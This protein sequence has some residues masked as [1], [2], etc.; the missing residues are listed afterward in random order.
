MRHKKPAGEALQLGHPYFDEVRIAIARSRDAQKTESDAQKVKVH[1]KK[2]MAQD[3][4]LNPLWKTGLFESMRR[5]FIPFEEAVAELGVQDSLL[6]ELVEQSMTF[7]LV[8]RPLDLEV[9][10]GG[11]FSARKFESNTPDSE[12]GVPAGPSEVQFPPIQPAFLILPPYVA[13]DLFIKGEAEVLEF[14]KAMSFSPSRGLGPLNPPTAPR[15]ADPMVISDHAK[16]NKRTE[17]W[18][19]CEGSWLLT[20]DDKQVSAKFSLKDVF[21]PVEEL[22]LVNAILW[23]RRSAVTETPHSMH[24]QAAIEA[25]TMFWVEPKAKARSGQRISEPKQEEVVAWLI[26]RTGMSHSMAEGVARLIRP[27]TASKGGPK[28]RSSKTMR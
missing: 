27:S 25:S 2:E 3:S 4:K 5:W 15:K 28:P 20:R 22:K 1:Q 18:R 8:R 12:E 6:L 17:K 19:S 26:K 9:Q 13:F 24:L 10:R 11:L 14:D 21:L 23:E 7:L 16:V